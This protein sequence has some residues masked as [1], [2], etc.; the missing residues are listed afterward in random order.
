MQFTGATLVLIY[1]GLDLARDELRT[2]IGLVP[3]VYAGDEFIQETE[4][5]IER[6]TKLRQRIAKKLPPEITTESPP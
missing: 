1:E 5:R 4:N 3:N 2:Q 6:L